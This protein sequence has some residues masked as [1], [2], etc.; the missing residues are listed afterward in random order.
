MVEQKQVPQAVSSIVTSAGDRIRINVSTSVKGV[1]TYDC[2]V[3]S[4]HGIDYTFDLH[5]QL[6]A[7]LDSEYPPNIQS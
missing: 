7:R 4:Q 6:V 2:T 3:E 1:K 5:R